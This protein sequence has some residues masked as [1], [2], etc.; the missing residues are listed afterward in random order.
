M[1]LRDDGQKT[2]CVNLLKGGVHQRAVVGQTADQRVLLD[3]LELFLGRGLAL[4]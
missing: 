2:S 1:Q 3:K 4:Q